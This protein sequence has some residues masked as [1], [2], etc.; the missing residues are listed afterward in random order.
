MNLRSVGLSTVALLG[1]LPGGAFA[2][3]INATSTVQLATTYPANGGF[4]TADTIFT[5]VIGTVVA[6]S[7]SNTDSKTGLRDFGRSLGAQSHCVVRAIQRDAI[8]DL[9]SQC[10]ETEFLAVEQPRQ[11]QW[12]AF[13]FRDGLRAA[14][15]SCEHPY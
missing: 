9:R 2:V 3:Q 8:H 1:G 11:L 5:L 15:T 12:R 13:R 14:R 10:L 6:R 7:E 4:P